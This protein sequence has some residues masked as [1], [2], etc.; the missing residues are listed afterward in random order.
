M[1]NK[2]ILLVGDNPFQGVSHLSQ[3]RVRERSQE[4]SNPE[5]CASL[6]KIATQNGAS[7]FMFSISQSTL[8]ILGILNRSRQMPRLYAIAPAAS[9]YVRLASR[10]GTPGLIT[11][12]IK[13]IIT[14]RNYGSIGSGFKGIL[15]RN[16][17]DLM[18]AYVYYELSRIKSATTS[19]TNPYSFLLHEIVT[20]MGI[21]LNLEWLFKE[22]IDFLL[23]LKI[24]PGFETRNSPMLIER[25]TKW[26]V[27]PTQ[28]VIVAPF[29]A[30]G[31]QMCPSREACE[32]AVLNVPDAEVIAMSALASGYLKIPAAIDYINHLPQ[33]KGIVVGISNDQQA[34]DFKIFREAL[35][36]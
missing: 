9:D 34:R 14:S 18:K 19:Y 28:V 2:K 13:Q 4:V 15:T 35:V 30:I 22:Y 17:A 31:F 1:N 33:L 25:L 8:A 23:G 27:D 16:P 20:E 36:G 12:L 11:Y 3:G 32:K 10:M 7:G 5:Y 29:N 21:A 6:I 26:G 24:K